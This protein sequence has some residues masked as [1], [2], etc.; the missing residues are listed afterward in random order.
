MTA[1]E[2]LLSD[3]PR[4]IPILVASL[5]GCFILLERFFAAKH[6]HHDALDLL[7]K[8]KSLARS[9]EPAGVQGFLSHSES[10]A[11]AVF[12]HG[13][14]GQNATSPDLARLTE[15]AWADELD[16]MERPLTA[17][18][19]AALV[20]FLG[21]LLPLLLDL[22]DLARSTGGL[23]AGLPVSSAPAIILAILG[24]VVAGLLALGLFLVRRS[25][26][27]VRAAARSLIPEFIHVLHTLGRDGAGRA[28]RP[29]RSSLSAVMPGEDEFFR[30]RA[31]ASSG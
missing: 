4:V 19:I 12:V 25:V 3:A 31:P 8:L 24:C 17:C 6:L 23:S 16:R 5:A 2:L 30:P 27:S 13:V 22:L 18:G 15:S 26:H 21:G 10:R 7:V 20:A 1:L 9:G 11:A 28:P 29:A 14:G